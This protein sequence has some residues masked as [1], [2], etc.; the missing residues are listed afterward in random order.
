MGSS[1][2]IASTLLTSFCFFILKEKRKYSS[3]KFLI[4]KLRLRIFLL[5]C[6]WWYE[7]FFIIGLVYPSFASYIYKRF[8]ETKSFCHE[9][10]KLRGGKKVLSLQ[11]SDGTISTRISLDRSKTYCTNIS[12]FFFG[13][14]MKKVNPY[15]EKNS[16]KK[17]LK[18]DSEK[19]F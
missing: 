5:L 3:H 14:H 17:V 13:P 12:W 18:S 19:W 16:K 11:K 6:V 8:I 15:W 7:D 4:R 10:W 9:V 2:N 1:R